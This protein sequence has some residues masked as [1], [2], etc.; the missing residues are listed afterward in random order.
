VRLPRVSR[1]NP[2]PVCGHDHWCYF[3]DEY[4]VVCMRVP[5]GKPK[6]AKGFGGYIHRLDGGV[7]LP[8][9]LPVREGRRAGPAVLD[10]TYQAFL[11]RPELALTL[12]DYRRFRDEWKLPA[13]LVRKK[14]YR[15]LPLKGRAEICRRLLEEGYS[16]EGVPGFYARDGIYGPYWTFTTGPGLVFP[17][18]SP[19]GK[20]QGL[21]V[22]LDD[23]RRGKYLWFSSAELPGGA[24]SGAPWHVARPSRPIRRAVIITEGIRKA[25]VVAEYMGAVTVGLGGV[26]AIEGVPEYAASLKMPVIIAYDMDVLRK[27]EVFESFRTLVGKLKG[28]VFVAAWDPEYNG[29]DCKGLDDLLVNSG[30]PK[31][32]PVNEAM[33]KIAREVRAQKK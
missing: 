7:S 15:R 21:Q 9:P 25:D 10:R 23:P 16:L 26:A 28:D 22:R 29:L 11:S 18:L 1:R 14:G 17:S 6:R 5:S 4:T 32:I 2:C 27:R 13:E 12:E 31:I 20:I 30:W 3:L 8:P 24:S 19:D 33:R